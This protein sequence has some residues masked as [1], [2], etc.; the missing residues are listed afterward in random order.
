MQNNSPQPLFAKKQDDVFSISGSLDKSSVPR[1]WANRSA[2]IKKAGDTFSIDLSEVSHCDSAGIAFLIQ[3][4]NEILVSNKT[5]SLLN[6]TDQ[7]L[8]LIKL[9][10]LED[11]LHT[12]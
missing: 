3:L 10:H 12:N 7:I 5:I 4:Q 8:K 1:Y 2:L 6:P 11:I 9:S